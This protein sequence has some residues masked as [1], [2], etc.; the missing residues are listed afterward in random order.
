MKDLAELCLT[1]LFLTLM[2]PPLTYAQ[3][4]GQF[5]ITQSVTAGGGVSSTACN[6]GITGTIAQT[7][8][9]D[10][11]MGGLFAVKSGFWQ[12]FLGPTAAGGASAGGFCVLAACRL[13]KRMSH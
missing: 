3:S 9:G 5:A 7:N 2:L 4:G 12:S 13:E 1:I 10:N 11:S 8:A 6:F